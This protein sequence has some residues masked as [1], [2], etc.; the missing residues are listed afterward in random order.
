[1]TV[2]TGD[3]PDTASNYAL[4]R[5]G[6]RPDYFTTCL[7]APQKGTAVS[8]PVGATTAPVLG[9]AMETTSVYG[10]TFSWRQSNHTAPSATGTIPQDGTPNRFL[11]ERDPNNTDYPY[12][13]AD[14]SA[15]L[16]TTINQLRLAEQTQVLLERD[17]R[18]GTRY[19]E[20]LQ[21]HFGVTSPDF[22][23]QRPEYL[24][25]GVTDINF[26]PV[27]LTTKGDGTSAGAQGN[28]AAFATAAAQG[29][30]F[31]KS[32]T[33]HGVIIGLVHVGADLTYQQGLDRMW[34]RSTRYDFAWPSFAHLGEQAVLNQE[35]YF[36][37]N[38]A[39]GDTLVF[40]YQERYGEYRRKMSQI[41]GKF[42][43][44]YSSPLDTYHL[45]QNFGSL[46]VLG[47]TFISDN[48]PV[49]RIVAVTSEPQFFLD[50]F[51]KLKCARPLPVYGIPTLAGRM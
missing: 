12:I 14:L 44:T 24:G 29:H 20:I 51:I 33:E 50:V 40:G 30:G 4:R 35:I 45:A 6:K 21:S 9:I 1:M 42:R 41:T 11:V 34:T 32:F 36:A 38:G 47:D 43:S 16:A 39:S 15:A 31:N 10:S 37:G 19:T 17:A 22:R 48:P 13:R 26:H 27:P 28:L 5:R 25:G 46:P 18:G 2:D 3:G 7:T 23:L 49:N 8:I